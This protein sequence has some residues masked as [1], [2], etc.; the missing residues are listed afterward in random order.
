MRSEAETEKRIYILHCKMC[1][2][3]LIKSNLWVIGFSLARR[4]RLQTSTDKKSDG[5]AAQMLQKK[6]PHNDHVSRQNE[7]AT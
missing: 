3:K 5:L 1:F 4:T 6:S 7:L 2:V